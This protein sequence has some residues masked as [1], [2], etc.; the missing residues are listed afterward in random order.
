MTYI[1]PDITIVSGNFNLFIN[2]LQRKL[3]L[4]TVILI[5]TDADNLLVIPDNSFTEGQQI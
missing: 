4:V 1:L 2:I 3:L 5:Q